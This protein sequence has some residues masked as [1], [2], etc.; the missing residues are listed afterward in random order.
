MSYKLD[1]TGGVMV[2]KNGAES[3]T[4]Y[5]APTI[6]K[7]GLTY[8]PHELV[9]TCGAAAKYKLDGIRIYG[10][11]Q[12]TKQA[13]ELQAVYQNLRTILQTTT[14][15]ETDIVA[16]AVFVPG[17]EANDTSYTDGTINEIMLSSGQ[18]VAFQ[19]EGM[20][21]ADKMYI[22]LASAAG[23]AAQVT[24]SFGENAVERYDFSN[25]V[26]T[27]YEVKTTSGGYVYIKNT[28]AN[29]VS[30]TDLKI[31][32]AATRMFS[33]RASAPLMR[34]VESFDALPLASEVVETPPEPSAEPEPTP[35]AD[36]E[37]TPSADPEP[38]QQPTFQD[39]I[40]DLLSSFVNA[41]FGSISRLFGRP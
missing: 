5:N 21:T 11:T 8:G 24:V 4:Y 39:I 40:S 35:S 20:G 12:D 27:F 7:L 28:G 34:Y 16:G 33:F 31:V 6:R 15:V 32:P 36:P 3:A 25:T 29:L 17:G 2:N 22:G 23:G 14:P 13:K 26:H 9:I 41:L 18:G 37:P 1:G 19:V 38:T 30:V 10:A